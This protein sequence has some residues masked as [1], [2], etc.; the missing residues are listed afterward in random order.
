MRLL[1]KYRWSIGAGAV[2]LLLLAYLAVAFLL[3][4]GATL[5]ERHPLEAHPSDFGLEFEDVAFPPRGDELTLRGWFMDDAAGGPGLVIVHG[6]DSQRSADGAVELAARLVD[7]G[8]GVLL[9]DLRGHG[10]SDGSRVTAGDRERRDVLGAYDL[11]AG[12]G[13][14]PVGVIGFSMGAGISIMAAAQEPGI[15][16]LVADSPFARLSDLLV[17]EAA[18]RTFLSEDVI[19]AFVPP[20]KL[21]ANLVYGIDVDELAPEEDV[22]RLAYPVLVI[23]GEGDARIPVSHGRRIHERAPS[24]S[25]IWTPQ[26]VDHVDAFIENPDEYVRRLLDYLDPRMR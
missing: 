17:Q 1:R 11:L 3:A 6:I 22:S 4:R 16:A 25:E 14:D 26:G 19:P 20:A 13:M 12:R 15:S 9:F 2:L 23:H 7:E 21:F 24:G 10:L 18:R 5:A 8:F